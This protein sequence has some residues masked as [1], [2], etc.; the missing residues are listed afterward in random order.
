MSNNATE[1]GYGTFPSSD[2][3]VIYSYRTGNSIRMGVAHFF[4]SFALLFGQPIEGRLLNPGLNWGRPILF[5]A[6]SSIL[7]LGQ[8][9]IV[10][11]LLTLLPRTQIVMLAGACGLV[12]SRNKL[13]ALKGTWRV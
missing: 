1:V 8:L 13:S 10:C 11:M 6:V 9:L 4:S 12:L 7:K 2:T 5:S 3:C